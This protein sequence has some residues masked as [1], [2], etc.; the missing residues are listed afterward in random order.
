MCKALE[1]GGPTGRFAWVVFTSVT[2][3]G[4]LKNA[5]GE[6]KFVH[7]KKTHYRSVRLANT[8]LCGGRVWVYHSKVSRLHCILE[9][10]SGIWNDHVLGL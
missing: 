3:N 8:V 1:K 9:F 5:A 4:A 6:V 2:T 7:L 10:S